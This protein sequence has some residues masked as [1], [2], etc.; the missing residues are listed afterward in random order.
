MRAPTF[1]HGYDNIADNYFWTVKIPTG[2]LVQNGFSRLKIGWWM[3]QLWW[4]IR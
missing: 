3:L 4:R 2:W 1:E